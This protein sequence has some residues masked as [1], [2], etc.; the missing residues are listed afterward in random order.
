MRT[1]DGNKH[2]N[3]TEYY[4]R[5]GGQGRQ[6]GSLRGDIELRPQSHPVVFTLGYVGT[7]R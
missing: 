3:V 2:G 5:G 4:M 7:R 6:G 1:A